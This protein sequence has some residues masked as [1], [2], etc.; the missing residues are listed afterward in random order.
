[1][2][3]EY[4]K[5]I[6]TRDRIIFGKYQPEEYHGGIRRFSELDA[7]VLEKLIEEKFIDPE[8]CQNL[9]PTAWEFFNF[10]KQYPW[11]MAHGYVVELKRPD[12]RMTIEGIETEMEPHDPEELCE[13]SKLCGDADDFQ[14]TYCWYD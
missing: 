13:Y 2:A 10:M 6:E 9:S 12:Y 3:F 11:W 1:M 7:E 4:N 14:T 5:D 8:D